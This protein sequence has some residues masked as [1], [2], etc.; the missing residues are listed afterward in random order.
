MYYADGEPAGYALGEEIGDG[1]MFVIHFEKA[2]TRFRGLYQFVNMSFAAI[3]PQ[4]YTYINREQDLGIEGLR[5]AKL[6]YQPAGFVKK[7]RVYPRR[8]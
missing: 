2:L 4:K 1:K 8:G 5:K 3:L 7:Y 6:S